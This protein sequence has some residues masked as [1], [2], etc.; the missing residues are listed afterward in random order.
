MCGFNR[1]HLGISVRGTNFLFPLL[2]KVLYKITMDKVLEFITVHPFGYDPFCQIGTSCHFWN[3]RIHVG[4]VSV[5]IQ[6]IA[7]SIIMPLRIGLHDCSGCI[8][9]EIGH[10]Y[11]HCRV[12]SLQII[13]HHLDEGHI[14]VFIFPIYKDIVNISVQIMFGK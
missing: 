1:S 5:R 11:R 9:E 12:G 8:V 2:P 4:I 3:I 6:I 7:N 14:V 10:K 13:G